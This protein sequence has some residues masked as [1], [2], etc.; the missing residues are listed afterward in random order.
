VRIA[1]LLLLVLAA[2]SALGADSDVVAEIGS[3]TKLTV[4]R[5][6][7]ESAARLTA[8]YRMLRDV[9]AVDSSALRACLEETLATLVDEKIL[10]LECDRLEVP[11]GDAEAKAIDDEVTLLA[12]TLASL[13]VPRE[14][15]LERKRLNAR[16]GHLLESA[17]SMR[18]IAIPV[19]EARAYYEAHE[20]E[21]ALPA[22]TIG[23]AFD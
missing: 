12:D 22:R 11:L 2:S 6:E 17:V 13:Q 7:L 19:E 10:R 23:W 15:L 18:D 4:T 14:H 1:A 16:I 8:R 3:T 5:G 9:A 21:F 20:E